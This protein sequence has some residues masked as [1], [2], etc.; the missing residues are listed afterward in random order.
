MP[1]ISVAIQG[2]VVATPGTVPATGAAS[3]TW[4]AGPVSYQSY[5]KLKVGGNVI[6]QA[7][8][9]FNFSGATSGGSAVTDVSTVTLTAGSTKLQKGS[10]FVLQN[11]DQKSDSFGNKLQAQSSRKLKSG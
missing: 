8:C 10:T 7:S 2:D 6:H 11:G 5:S 1:P 3:G 4:T 9:T